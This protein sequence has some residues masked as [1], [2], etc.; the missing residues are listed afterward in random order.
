[1]KTKEELNALKEEVESLY[2]K[3]DELTAEELAQV[4]GG[5]GGANG[6]IMVCGGRSIVRGDIVTA[7]GSV[8]GDGIQSEGEPGSGKTLLG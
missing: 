3:L 2:K 4:S 1:M 7:P 5:I 6:V 8:G